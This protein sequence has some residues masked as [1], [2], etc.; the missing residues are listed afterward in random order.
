MQ[1]GREGKGRGGR[2]A[3]KETTYKQ[4]KLKLKQTETSGKEEVS[5]RG[6]PNKS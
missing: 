1:R 6:A 2:R 3:S 4:K 5:E